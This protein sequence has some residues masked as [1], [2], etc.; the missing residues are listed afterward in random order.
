M[1]GSKGQWTR[2]RI[3]RIIWSTCFYMVAGGYTVAVVRTVLDGGSLPS[4][5][6]LSA[7]V[8]REWFFGMALSSLLVTLLALLIN[9]FWWSKKQPT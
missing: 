6:W 8:R 1:A 9:R 3:V 5:L 4:A 2:E 7:P